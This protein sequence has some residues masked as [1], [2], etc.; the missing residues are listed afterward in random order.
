MAQYGNFQNFTWDALE[1]AK[2]S[3]KSLVKMTQWNKE[4]SPKDDVINQEFDQKVKEILSDNINTPKLLVEIFNELNIHGPSIYPALRNLEKNFLKIGLFEIQ[5]EV[6]IPS[7]ITSL[8]DQRLQ[9]KQEKNYALAD[10][11]RSQITAAGR[12]VKDTKDGYELNKL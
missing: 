8:A 2:N 12:E 5:E 11:L 7:D 9:A 4:D 3:R 6:E 10:E 1:Q